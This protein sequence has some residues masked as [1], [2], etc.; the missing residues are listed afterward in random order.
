MLPYTH[1]FESIGGYETLNELIGHPNA[2][3]YEI[4][5]HILEVYFRRD[6]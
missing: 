3:I 4:T 2:R 5:K 1:Y 6:G